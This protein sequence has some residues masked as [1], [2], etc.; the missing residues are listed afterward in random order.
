MLPSQR[1]EFEP[2]QR[3]AFIYR[4]AAGHPV[5]KIPPIH[6]HRPK[7]ALS[8]F[9]PA[10]AQPAEALLPVAQTQS[11]PRFPKPSQTGRGPPDALP[12]SLHHP[13]QPRGTRSSSPQTLWSL[14]LAGFVSFNLGAAAELFLRTV[15]AFP[16]GSVPRGPTLI[17]TKACLIEARIA[18]ACALTQPLMDTHAHKRRLLPT[19]C[20]VAKVGELHRD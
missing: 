18:G 7:T 15:S 16:S 3:T 12:P 10:K 4:W 20:F 2:C 5:W 9:D 14:G 11:C 1:C 13:S 6:L 19:R 8:G 17:K